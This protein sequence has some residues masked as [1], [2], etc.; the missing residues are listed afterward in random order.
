[1]PNSN[2]AE[3]EGNLILIPLP[4][5]PE[6]RRIARWLGET[7]VAIGVPG[8]QAATRRALNETL[9]NH[10]RL[11]DLFDGVTRLRQRG[12]N[13]LDA[14]RTATV[15]LGN[16]REVTPVHGVEPGGIDLERLQRLVGGTPINRGHAVNEREIAH[17]SQQ[18]AGNARR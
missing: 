12:R 13:G 9:L 5:Q 7:E 10:E 14:D 6:L 15:V 8:E 1:M 11:D 16:H 17:A 4:E 3:R 2:R 18:P